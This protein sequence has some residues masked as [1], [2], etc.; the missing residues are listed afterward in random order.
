[1][2]LA[3]EQ[4]NRHTRYFDPET[5]WN[6]RV[7]SFSVTRKLVEIDQASFETLP[8]SRTLHSTMLADDKRHPRF[9]LVTVRT[10]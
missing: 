1:M 2:L 4:T 8:A 6:S 10:S 3:I 7:E 5:G 9:P